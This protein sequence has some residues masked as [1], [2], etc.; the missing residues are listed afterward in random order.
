MADK[1]FLLW[2]DKWDSNREPDFKG[3]F[4]SKEK[5]LDVELLPPS[6][7]YYNSLKRVFSDSEDET[8]THIQY[9]VYYGGGP[10][11]DDEGEYDVV[12]YFFIVEMNLD[13]YLDDN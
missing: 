8:V 7:C 11:E 6:S 3:V 2:F 10:Y 13:E 4:S 1:V 5:A 9:I 12:R